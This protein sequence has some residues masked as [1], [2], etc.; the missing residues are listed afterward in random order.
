V[1]QSDALDRAAI[2]IANA[3]LIVW[4]VPDQCQLSYDAGHDFV[5]SNS[6]LS[7]IAAAP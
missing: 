2:H 1:T 4:S 5:H 6:N 3:V 7:A